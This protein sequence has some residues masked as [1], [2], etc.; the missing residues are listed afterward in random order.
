MKKKIIKRIFLIL[1]I[2]AITPIIV[3]TVYSFVHENSALGSLA[4]YQALYESVHIEELEDNIVRITPKEGTGDTGIVFYPGAS[5]E[6]IAYVP[7]LS[8]LSNE[9]YTIYLTKMPHNLAILD[10]DR[11][12]DIFDMD[13]DIEKWYIAGHSMGGAMAQKYAKNNEEM[14]D[15]LIMIAA[16]TKYDLTDSSL[17][18]IFLYGSND[19]LVSDKVG[20]NAKYNPVDAEEY[21][22]EGGNHAQFGDYE[23]QIFDS[24]ATISPEQQRQTAVELITDWIKRHDK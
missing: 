10:S 4:E 8:M 1:I 7:F 17:P 22:I 20:D 14:F 15:G 18:L 21:C 9:G 16:T 24:E 19:S 12:E 6:Y 11:I 2:L 5:V 23:G 3:F 13:E